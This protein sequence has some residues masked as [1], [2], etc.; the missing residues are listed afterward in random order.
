[1]LRRRGAFKRSTAPEFG[2]ENLKRRVG[3]QQFF[4]IRTGTFVRMVFFD[5]VPEGSFDLVPC[6][7]FVE[8][9]RGERGSRGRI[10]S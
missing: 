4:R 1:M 10:A 7:V 9:E 8:V 6:G 2:G 3:Q 5:D